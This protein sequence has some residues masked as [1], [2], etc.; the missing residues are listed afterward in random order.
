MKYLVIQQG[1]GGGCSYLNRTIGCNM[2]FDFIE[3][4]NT[5]ELEEKILYPYGRDEC[6]ILESE[7]AVIKVMYV[8][9]DH[10]YKMPL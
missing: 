9:L 10:V 1:E 3:A 8:E 7:P 2:R 6:S 5:E 4:E